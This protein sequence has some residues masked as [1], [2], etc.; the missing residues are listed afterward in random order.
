[1]DIESFIY[2]SLCQIDRAIVRV[3]QELTHCEKPTEKLPFIIQSGDISNKSGIEFD[4]A[5]TVENNDAASGGVKA[6]LSV[7]SLDIGGKSSESFQHVSRVKFV[8]FPDSRIG[9]TREPAVSEG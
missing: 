3:N 6:S 5:V 8:I 4:I 1:M 9:Y 2:E 7:V